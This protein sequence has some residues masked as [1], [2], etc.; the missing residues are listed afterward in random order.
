MLCKVPRDLTWMRLRK[1]KE[2]RQPENYKD[3]SRE[4]HAD[5]SASFEAD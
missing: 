4:R 1:T 2:M 5:Y 3:D